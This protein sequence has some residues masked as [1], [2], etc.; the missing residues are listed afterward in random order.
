MT[1]LRSTLMSF[2]LFILWLV[3]QSSSV[4]AERAYSAAD[5]KFAQE[6]IMKGQKLLRAK[7]YREALPYFQRSQSRVPDVKTLY[8]LGA[9][10]TKL[11]SC[12][13]AFEYWR[14]AQK[15]CGGCD[16]QDRISSSILR[17]TDEC[18]GEISLQSLPRA[19]VLIDGQ[20]V[21]FT[22]FNQ[23]LLLGSHYLELQA[24]GHIPLRQRIELIRGRPFLL[25]ITLEP[26]GP[27]LGV[28]SPPFTSTESQQPDETFRPDRPLEP[29]QWLSPE[30]VTQADSSQTSYLKIT[31]YV[32]SAV[33]AVTALGLYGYSSS[34]FQDLI[35]E[36]D[37][38]RMTNSPVV[39]SD[40]RTE[41]D[42]TQTMYHASILL[43]SVSAVTL[44]TSLFL[45]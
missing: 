19:E 40:L 42:H 27:Q 14:D 24:T 18:A 8:T 15:L 12:I 13:S 21:G 25:D 1:F 45:D 9:I 23:R 28:S 7:K 26:D 37:N 36:R 4:S 35:E 16:F 41:R 39:N 44:I 20:A 34:K 6:Q 32:T 3:I 5:L 31:L 10:H 43:G 30:E 38:L 17:H 2:T 33:M 22:P 29:P 11:K